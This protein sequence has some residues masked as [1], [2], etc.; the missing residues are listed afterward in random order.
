[1]NWRRH[2]ESRVP[3]LRDRRWWWRQLIQLVVFAVIYGV[4]GLIHPSGGEVYILVILLASGIGGSVA[5]AIVPRHVVDHVPGEYELRLI[6]AGS[7]PL[8]VIKELRASC[9]MSSREARRRV[10]STPTTF[11][12]GDSPDDAKHIAARLRAAGAVTALPEPSQESA[13]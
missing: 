1:M 12:V 10:A 2:V 6:S 8:N 11:L 4:A 9:G 7:R 13:A 5:N 3:V